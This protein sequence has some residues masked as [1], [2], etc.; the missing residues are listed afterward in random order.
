MHLLKDNSR[1][2]EFNLRDLVSAAGQNTIQL[3]ASARRLACSNR[4]DVKEKNSKRIE[5]ETLI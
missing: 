3:A 4:A 5:E 2:T 1:F